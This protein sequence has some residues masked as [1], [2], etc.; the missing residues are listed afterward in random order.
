MKRLFFAVMCFLAFTGAAFASAGGASCNVNPDSIN[1]EQAI[2]VE[3]GAHYCVL[4][5]RFFH[6][7]T[8]KKTRCF[9]QP[10]KFFD[11]AGGSGDTE[12]AFWIGLVNLT[13]PDRRC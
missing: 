11:A 9:V 10:E 2:D 4:G 12:G 7:S 13:F 8:K 5:E 3:T 1:P 6:G